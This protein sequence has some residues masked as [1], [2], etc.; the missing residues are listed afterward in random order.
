MLSVTLDAKASF[1][2]I[3]LGE[4]DLRKAEAIALTDI[5]TGDRVMVRGKLADD[6]KSMAAT[7][8]LVMSQS[9]VAKK[10]AADRADWDK[11]GV[12]GEVTGT[13]NDKFLLKVRGK[14]MTVMLAPNA[15]V[16]R[17]AQDSVKFSDAKPSTVAEIR[18]GDQA[19]ARGAKSEDGSSMVAEEVVFG[20]FRTV[21]AQ[22]LSV[23]AG[24]LK[25]RDLDAK[26]PITLK[27]GGD[28]TL[29]KM[30][31]QMAQM[32]A[33]TKQAEK[34]GSAPGAGGPPAAAPPAEGRGGG[35][36]PGGS[37]GP[38]DGRGGGR[39]GRVGNDLTQMLDRF[40][41][42]AATD[43]KPG[44][45]LIVLSSV[46]TGDAL[47]VVT[48]LAG[49]EPILTRPG[50]REMSLGSWSLNAGGGGGDGN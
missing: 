4:T 13:G 25:V 11:R 29:K 36:G 19:R 49:V 26:K 6:Q 35:R 21:A 7:L 40:P 47:T 1:R 28:S 15:A 30:P 22:V 8:V 16:R 10:Q 5:T 45:A 24:V 39:G 32:I 50:T 14:T 20:S 46:G 37:G 23:E 43:L 12:S 9:D 41:G 3:A 27:L 48:L 33:L 38:P 18:S 17:Y 42:I 34:D 44:D 2:K 31:E